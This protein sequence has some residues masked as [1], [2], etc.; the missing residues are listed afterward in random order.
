MLHC[1]IYHIRQWPPDVASATSRHYHNIQLWTNSNTTCECYKNTCNSEGG[2]T[3]G[4]RMVKETRGKE[5]F[6]SLW[7][8]IC[9]PFLQKVHIVPVDWVISVDTDG[10]ERYIYKCHCTYNTSSCKTTSYTTD[11]YT[12]SH[13]QNRFND[14]GLWTSVQQVI[15]VDVTQNFAII[16]SNHHRLNWETAQQMKRRWSIKT[17]R[18]CSCLQLVGRHL[19]HL[20][21]RGITISLSS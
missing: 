21:H 12:E 10:G 1:N 17:V 20:H 4:R 16:W 8:L 15:S 13:S 2:S 5:R 19:H 6:F 3:D 18:R 9:N 14:G 11:S 7:I